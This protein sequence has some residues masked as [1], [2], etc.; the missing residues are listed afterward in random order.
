MLLSDSAADVPATKFQPR[1]ILQLLSVL[2][3]SM[4]VELMQSAAASESDP[5]RINHHRRSS[6]L[7]S[8]SSQQGIRRHASEQALEGY[9]A[10]HHMLLFFAQKKYPELEAMAKKQVDDFVASPH[11]RRKN[12]TPDLGRLL[13]CLTLSQKGWSDLW[14][15]FLMENFDRNVRW[16]LEKFPELAD[17]RHVGTEERLR[18]TFQASLTS[19]RL[20]MFQVHFVS[21]IGQPPTTNNN[22]RRGPAEVLEQYEKRLGRPTTAQKEELQMAC[23]RILAVSTWTEFFERCQ[24][25]VPS[26]YRLVEMLEQAVINSYEKRYHQSDHHRRTAKRARYNDDHHHGATNGRR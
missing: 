8:F 26:K 11:H 19:L 21:H 23:K 16:V 22:T 15:P 24:V 25:P 13:V 12:C 18:K 1:M 17:L 4:V 5:H 20:V 6:S 10:F 2:M 9:C 14:Q 3:N 7:S